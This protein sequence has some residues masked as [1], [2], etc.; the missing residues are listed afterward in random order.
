[1]QGHSSRLDCH[2]KIYGMP[3]VHL[4][5][6]SSCQP[7]AESSKEA[8]IYYKMNHNS[9]QLHLAYSIQATRVVIHLWW[10]L[11]FL[12]GKT[13]KHKMMTIIQSDDKV[14][15]NDHKMSIKWHKMMTKSLKMTRKGCKLT[16]KGHKMTTRWHIMSTKGCRMTTKGPWMVHTVCRC[17][18]LLISGRNG[19]GPF[20]KKS[21]QM[22][23]SW[24][25]PTVIWTNSSV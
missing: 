2:W 4:C 16:T 1:M 5:N 23:I 6:L 21:A 12:V 17:S 15:Q 10:V 8:I 22:G 14:T 7:L 20:I 13:I 9:C 3:N 18:L 19:H 24:P 11:T 25:P